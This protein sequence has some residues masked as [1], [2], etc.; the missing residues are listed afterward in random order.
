MRD[1]FLAMMIGLLCKFKVSSWF[2]VGGLICDMSSSVFSVSKKGLEHRLTAASQA[3]FLE[4]SRTCGR[5]GVIHQ[6]HCCKRASAAQKEDTDSTS[7][8][9]WDRASAAEKVHKYNSY[10]EMSF[11][12][13]FKGCGVFL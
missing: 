3:T 13:S 9:S 7:H 5:P 2:S 1:E 12:S 8:G 11:P 10:I 4:P 6:P